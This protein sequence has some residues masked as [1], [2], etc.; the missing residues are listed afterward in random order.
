MDVYDHDQRNSRQRLAY[1]HINGDD[2]DVVVVGGRAERSKPTVSVCGSI[3]VK[4]TLLLT[5]I[6]DHLHQHIS[7]MAALFSLVSYYQI[8]L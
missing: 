3:L 2:D 6:R 7:E 1:D 8:N 5:S 4:R